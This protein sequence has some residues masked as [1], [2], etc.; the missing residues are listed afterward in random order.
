MPHDYVID[1]GKIFSI[2]F[3]MLGP[4]RFIDTYTILTKDVPGDQRR[5]LAVKTGLIA[6]L[7]LLVAGLLGAKLISNWNVMPAALLLAVGLIFFVV[8]VSPIMH[9][10]VRHLGK[11]ESLAPDELALH[12]VITPYGM[13]ALI[14]L[15]SVAHDLQRVMIIIGCLFLV[16]MLNI[17][18]MAFNKPGK[19]SQKS[20]FSKILSSVLGTMQFA[21]AIQIIISSL[22]SLGIIHLKS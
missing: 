9:G 22:N 12:L 19:E 6:V 21:L 14:V 1:P 10:E 5:K 16:M 17:L 11:L 4:L 8:A 2:F 7:A 20:L 13:A 15:L 3:I 18:F